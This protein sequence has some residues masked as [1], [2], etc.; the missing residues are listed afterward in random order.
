MSTV[1]PSASYAVT[2]RLSIANRPGMLG[3]V[4]SVIGRAGG[5]IGAVDLV[6]TSRD[7]VLRAYAMIEQKFGAAL[8]GH[9][10]VIFGAKFRSRGDSPFY[11]IRVG[12]STREE[13]EKVCAG[14]RKAGAACLVLRNSTPGA[15]K[16]LSP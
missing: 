8:A 5:D 9:D 3:K 15:R 4:A 14:L 16:A 2:V 10:P 7:R 6:E 1:T 11:Q 12:A 13:A